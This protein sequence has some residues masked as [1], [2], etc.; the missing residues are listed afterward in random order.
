VIPFELA[1]P[2]SLRDALALLDPGDPSIRPIAGGTALMLMMKAGLFKPAKLVSL[3]RIEPAYSR[4]AT[5][6][7]GGLAIGAMAALADLEH[8][9]AVAAAAP[10]IT[11]ALRR[12]S[13]VRVR[14]VATVG[15]HLAHAD[16]H[17]DLPPVLIALG[18][19]L[20]IMGPEGERRIAVEDLFRG[21]YET[22]L[23][24]DELV[25][26]LIVP[27][28]R[29]GAAYLKVTTRSADDWPALGIAVA[30][31][32]AGGTISGARVAIS[33]ATEKPMRLAAV[34]AVLAGA[35][36]DEPTF[37]RAA[38]AA[39]AAAPV[40]GDVRGSAPYKRQ[41]VRVYTA[42]ALRAALAQT[43]GGGAR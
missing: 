20:V 27:P 42:R 24:A 18:A 25:T 31:D 26:Q 38:E 22:A 13:N 40:T 5:P 34:E 29:P 36:A 37:R 39:A 33:A 41:L 8:S 35:A 15:G 30:L 2:R 11:Q 3:R 4:I 12:L 1:E 32:L 14:N 6:A 21:Y 17:M 9:P 19:S 10:V 28:R 43:V 16:P 23:A 7:E